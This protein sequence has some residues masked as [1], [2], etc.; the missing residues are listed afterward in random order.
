MKIKVLGI[1][2]L[3][4]F[5]ACSPNK[6]QENKDKI[7]V[8]CTT[9]M[10]ADAAKAIFGNLAEVHCL[11]GPG[12]DPH[13]YKATQGDV[14]L[15]QSADLILYNGLHLEG[16]MTEIFK[17]LS[18]T[19]SCYPIAEA[20]DSNKLIF[21]AEGIPDPHIWFD[22]L[23]WRSA[24]RELANFLRNE[25]PKKELQ[26]K[27]N[28]TSYLAQLEELHFWTQ[29]MIDSIPANQRV[30]VTSHDAFAYFGKAYGLKVNALQ[31]IST[32]AE[33]GL[34]DV[35][36][37]IQF[38]LSHKLKSIFV[39]TSV[40]EKALQT[41]VEGITA[42]GGNTTI[43]PALYSDALGAEGTATGSF[44][45]VVQHNVSSICQGLK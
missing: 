12:V 37:L 1:A 31:G 23:L 9:G 25:Y 22:L 26:L 38:C 21:A 14:G 34:Q 30:L 2:I 29:E 43:G 13:L 24:V 6:K 45:G 42:K 19:K 41:V 27:E 8:V 20:L 10:V 17:K 11:M 36:S 16:K 4:L 40:N 28:A 44:I 33:F 35:Q 18:R 5:L 32:A 3:S 39:E 15:L 7:Q